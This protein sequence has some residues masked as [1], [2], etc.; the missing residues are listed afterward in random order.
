MSQTLPALVLRSQQYQEYDTQGLVQESLY[1]FLDQIVFSAVQTGNADIVANCEFIQ[2]VKKGSSEPNNEH[3][4]A[5]GSFLQLFVNEYA[6]RRIIALQQSLQEEYRDAA[7]GA[8]TISDSARMS[9]SHVVLRISILLF[10]LSI[11]FHS[12]PQF[13]SG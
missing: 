2:M 11:I 6:V 9:F 4:I 7:K 12:D 5:L 1:H 3:F 10:L 8:S 13:Y